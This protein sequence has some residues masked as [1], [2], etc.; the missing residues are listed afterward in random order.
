MAS[1]I[2]KVETDKKCKFMS[3]LGDPTMFNLVCYYD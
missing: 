2:K 3:L 1:V